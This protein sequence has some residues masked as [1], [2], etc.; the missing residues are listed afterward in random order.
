LVLNTFLRDTRWGG[1]LDIN[2]NKCITTACGEPQNNFYTFGSPTIPSPTTQSLK[3]ELS[4]YDLLP[5]QVRWKLHSSSW[6][7]WF[8]YSFF[9]FYANYNLKESMEDSHV[10]PGP[11]GVDCKK[12]FHGFSQLKEQVGRKELA[13]SLNNERGEAEGD[14]ID[15]NLKL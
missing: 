8:F 1:P 12:P 2:S 9:D 6:S 5:I 14:G 3:G 7:F 13:L 4:K 10:R 11:G 15:L